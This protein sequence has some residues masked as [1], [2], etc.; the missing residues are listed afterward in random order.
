LGLTKVLLVDKNPIMRLGLRYLIDE[1]A[2]LEVVGEA[3]D[4]RSA[5]LAAAELHP[6]V[7]VMEIAMPELNGVEAARHIL[8]EGNGTHVLAFAEEGDPR[9]VSRMLEAG[10]AGFLLKDS[11]VEEF[12]RAL[13][14][15]AVGKSY[16]DPE[17]AGLVIDQHVR[18]PHEDEDQDP[19][20]HHL[21]PRE[22]EVLQLVA[23]GFTNK[24]IGSRLHVSPKTVGTHRQ[25]IMK[26]LDTNNVV[27]LTKHAIRCGL[28]TVQT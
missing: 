4:G 8:A 12:V 28:T 25:N 18:H 1:T 20:F 26:K 19:I 14:A 16:L 24:E 9:N 6:D 17:V 13:R 22:R 5:V 27:A 10:A 11:P 21:T 2:D 23:E 15:V 3:D 7:V